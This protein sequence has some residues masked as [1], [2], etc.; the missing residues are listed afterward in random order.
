MKGL[1]HRLQEGVLSALWRM[2]SAFPR[3]VLGIA[4]LLTVVSAVY[5]WKHLG[6]SG[7]QDRLVSPDLPYQ[8]AHLE[9]LRNFGDQEYLYIVV[10]TGAGHDG[11]RLAEAFVDWLAGQLQCQDSLIQEVFYRVTPDDLGDAALQLAPSEDVAGLARVLDAVSPFVDAWVRDR[12]LSNLMAQVSRLFRE[13]QHTLADLDEAT[14]ARGFEWLAGFTGS[15]REVLQGKVPEGPLVDLNGVVGSYLVAGEGRFLIMK[16]LPAKDYSTLEVVDAPLDFI[17]GRLEEARKAFPGVRAGLTGRPALQADEMET[18]NRDMTRASIVD[19]LLVA[20]LFVLVLHGWLRP[21]LIMVT[22]GMA[23][24]WTFGFAAV[25]VGELNL[26]SV[27]FALVLVGIGVDYGVHIVM[28]TIEATHRGCTAEESVRTAIYH[29]GPG[30]VLGVACTVCTFYAVL[31]SDFKGLAE[32][33]LVGGTGILICLLAMMA[34]LP[35]MLLLAGRMGFFPSSPPRVVALPL[36][37]WFSDRPRAML[38]VLGALTLAAAPGLWKVRFDYNLLKLQ[39]QGLESVQYERLLTDSGDESTW[40]AVLTAQSVEEVRDRVHEVRSLPEVGKVE[41]ILDFLPK[42]QDD[43]FHS[44]AALRARVA[45]WAGPFPD[46]SPDQPES[47]AQSFESLKETLEALSEKLFASGAGME[48]T[49]VERSIEH[50]SGSAAALD[51][52]PEAAWRLSSF[53]RRVLTEVQAVSER[54]L[55]W[56]TAEGVTVERLPRFVQRLF[57]GQDGSFQVKVSPRGDVWD[58]DNLQRFVDMLRGVDPKVAGVPVVVLESA[59]LMHRTFLYAGA[60]TVALVSVIL[61]VYARSVRFALL[62]LAPLAVGVLWLL[63]AMGWLGVDFNLANFFAIPMLIAVGVD[64]GVHLLD[65]WGEL[66]GRAD[67]FSTSTPTAVA[68]SFLTTITGFGGLLF[69]DHQGLASLG[70]VMVLG[71]VTGMA[72]CLFVLPCALKLFGRPQT[73]RG[74]VS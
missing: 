28:R 19:S 23:I 55:R 47:L 39:S 44:L 1:H 50:L 66:E 63:E 49:L 20:L 27:V 7:D 73:G 46:P 71:S 2:V 48:L 5:S 31:G 45:G 67:L 43:G 58:F 17:R 10:E 36:L 61:W 60:V 33:G 11:R 26:L 70:A 24:A 52:D 34:V 74:T 30:I 32:L 29:T 35:A 8:K 57:I 14:V 15:I 62:A 51:R 72:A 13:G 40:Y 42:E 18:T 65:R 4:L 37:Q 53:W 56:V 68:T 9:I 6:M 3:G 59:H 16:I 12:A 54:L 22:L 21:L 25:T 64:G 69:A 38:A 41:S